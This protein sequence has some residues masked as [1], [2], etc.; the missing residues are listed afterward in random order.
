MYIPC[1]QYV[2]CLWACWHVGAI[3][4]PLSVKNPIGEL[5]YVLEKADPSNIYAS[6]RFI[7][8][9]S[10]ANKPFGINHLADLN[11]NEPAELND[12]AVGTGKMMKKTDPALIIFTSGT[13]GKIAVC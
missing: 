13:T 6:A 9:L 10:N 2:A 7:D 12:L 8:K 4:V 3:A 5:Q 11:L 1:V